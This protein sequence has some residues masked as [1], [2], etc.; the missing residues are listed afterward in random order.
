[1]QLRSPTPGLLPTAAL[2]VALAVVACAGPGGPSAAPGGRDGPAPSPKRLIVATIGDVINFNTKLTPPGTVRGLSDLEKL[3]TAGLTVEDER[4]VRHPQLAEQAPTIENGLWTVQPDGRMV[5]TWR[6]RSGASWQDGV[7]VTAN[8]LLFA[9][10]LGRDRDLPHFR[11]PLYDLIESIDA[12]DASTVTV[13]WGKTYIYADALFSQQ[14]ALPLPSHLLERLYTDDRERFTELPYWSEEF[15]G[16]GPYRV[17]SFVRGSH[18]VFVANDGYL[19]GRPKLD[20]IEARF[21]LDPNVLMANVLAGAVEVTLGGN[22]LSLEQAIQVRDQWRDGRMET[23]LAQWQLLYPQFMNPDPPVVADARFRQALLHAID[24]EQMADTIQ[25]GVVPVAHSFVSPSDPEYRDVERSIV[26]YEHDPRKASALIE[27]LGYRKGAEGLFRDA[28]NRPL[29]IQIQTS[30][31]DI[32][33]KSTFAVADYW[34][35]VGVSAE[36]S[37]TPPQ[38]ARDLEYRAAF[39]AFTMQRHPNDLS[40]LDNHYSYKA[41]VPDNN[42]VGSNY[43]RYQSAE[44]DALLDRFFTTIPVQQRNRTLA[45]IIHHMTDRVTTLGLFYGTDVFMIAHRL[46]GSMGSAWNVHEWDVR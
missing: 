36:P 6:I 27:G 22:S 31:T 7:P 34:Q 39:P 16:S 29:S 20:E 25:H 46:Q 42:F 37:V 14:V 19:M 17:R 1:M 30:T 23:R 28:A 21:F 24:R 9:A 13:R 33:Q 8:D 32:N 26:R 10:R 44:L 18:A 35:R 40:S 41:R 43:S 5:T 45:E 4:S 38:R 2:L 15:V 12:A 3:V 11:D